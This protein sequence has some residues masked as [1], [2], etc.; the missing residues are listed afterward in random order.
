MPRQACV[1]MEHERIRD[2]ISK[3]FSDLTGLFE[4]AAGL[5]V[6]GQ[7][8]RYTVEDLENLAAQ[9]WPEV[10]RTIK[11]LVALE[12]LITIYPRD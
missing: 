7:S 2:D 11:V 12:R 10:N 9:I 3:G 1:D 8:R 6:E 4:D 5:A